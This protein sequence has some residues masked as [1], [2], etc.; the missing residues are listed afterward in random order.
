MRNARWMACRITAGFQRTSR[1]TTREAPVRVTPSPQAFVEANKTRILSF[2]SLNR[3]IIFC[4]SSDWTFPSIC[5]MSRS[6]TQSNCFPSISSRSRRGSKFWQK[7]RTFSCPSRKLLIRFITNRVFNPT[8]GSRL[9]ATSI[10]SC[11]N[12]RRC[13]Y[14]SGDRKHPHKQRGKHT[15]HS[16]IHPFWDLRRIRW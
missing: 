13:E 4:L 12:Q 7:M 2:G 3:S 1:K 10:I 16:F 9:E 8:A 6:R 5:K 11:T 15:G 14:Q